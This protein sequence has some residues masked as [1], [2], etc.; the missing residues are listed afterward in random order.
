MQPEPVLHPLKVTAARPIA[1][2]IHLFEFRDPQGGDLPPFSAG[3]HLSL[4]VPNGE[5]RK[6]SL[7]NDPAERDRYVIAVQRDVTGRGGSRSLV[8]TVT[9]GQLLHVSEP[10]NDFALAPRAIQC[11]LENFFYLL[12]TFRGHKHCQCARPQRI[13]CSH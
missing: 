13:S 1:H 12:P 9:P 4:R 8:D 7:C 3:A 6:Y 10:R 11:R 2:D 5:L